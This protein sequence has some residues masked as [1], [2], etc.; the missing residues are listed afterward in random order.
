M[1]NSDLIT[2]NL[3]DD[4]LAFFWKEAKSNIRF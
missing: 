1:L 4:Y 3:C 2:I